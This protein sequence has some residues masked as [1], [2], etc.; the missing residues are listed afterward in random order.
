[1]KKSCHNCK[2]SVNLRFRHDNKE[3]YVTF[4]C[5]MTPS[6]SSTMIATFKQFKSFYCNNFE[7]MYFV[8]NK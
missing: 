4:D 7:S 2:H 6:Y 5:Y 8:K 3:R 1:M